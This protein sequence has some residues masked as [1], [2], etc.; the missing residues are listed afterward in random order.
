MKCPVQITSYK[1][2]IFSP[3]FSNEKDPGIYSKDVHCIS[4]IFKSLTYI[5][6]T[7][8][9]K[10]IRADKE[11]NHTICINLVSLRLIEAENNIIL[12]PDYH[13]KFA[14]ALSSVNMT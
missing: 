5:S 10:T 11:S 12:T 4:Y 3:Y 9:V 2:T 8:N 7:C 14:F 6:R 13:I 1:G